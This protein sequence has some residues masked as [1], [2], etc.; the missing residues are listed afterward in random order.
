LKGPA[1]QYQNAIHDDFK[2][3]LHERRGA[4]IRRRTASYHAAPDELIV[5]HP[6]YA[7]SGTP[8]DRSALWRLMCLPAQVI[9]EVTD[10]SMLR[11]DQPVLADPSLARRYRSLFGLFERSAPAI[12]CEWALFELLAALSA[13][14]A[15]APS[16]ESVRT[17]AARVAE[18]AREQ[19]AAN[20]TG[21][22][23]LAQ[24]AEVAG[25]SRFGVSR[26]CVTHYGLPPHALHLRLRLDH[27]C[28]LIR[29]GVRLV[30]VS[31]QSGFHDQAHFTRT[32]LRTYGM[33]PTQY[34][35][36]WG[37]TKGPHR[38]MARRFL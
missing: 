4:T 35:D 28:D 2:L 11:F 16:A 30:D 10:P 22:V 23:M 18:A 8:D 19:L 7:H 15:A 5:H 20:L 13:R 24:L 36:S 26:A 32:F 37:G 9:A 34:R 38:K 27:G 14:T 12:E 25:T 6:G 31:L 3:V 17:K 29:A 21:N 33:T 1:Q